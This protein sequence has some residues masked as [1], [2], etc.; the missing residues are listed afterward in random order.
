[1]F[2]VHDTKKLNKFINQT[3]N[4]NRFN[5]LRINPFDTLFAICTTYGIYVLTVIL[6]RHIIMD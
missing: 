6:V 1:M 5:K 3:L 4:I 2:I